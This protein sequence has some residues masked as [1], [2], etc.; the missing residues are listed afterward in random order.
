MDRV[1][2]GQD[3]GM[4]PTSSDGKKGAISSEKAQ[5]VLCLGRV[6]TCETVRKLYSS[7]GSQKEPI[8]RH[9]YIKYR[10]TS[11]KN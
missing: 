10:D 5:Y 3:A 9:V 2:K 11:A 4:W 1:M 7:I 6:L 8:Y